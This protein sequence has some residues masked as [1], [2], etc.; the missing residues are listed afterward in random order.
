[1]A[2]DTYRYTLSRE[3]NPDGPS[4]LFIML[5]PSTATATT[6]DRTMKRLQEIGILWRFGKIYVGNLYPYCSSR[7]AILTEVSIPP[8]V[9]EENIRSIREMAAL[10][11]TVV[12]AWGTKGPTQAEPAWLKEIVTGH[13][14]CI[15]KS[16]KG[17]PKHPLQWG[18]WRKGFPAKPVL[19]R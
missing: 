18:D 19:F 6:D 15:S 1:M 7:P 11:D 17:V 2:T 3:L 14:Y 5:N 9:M 8:E 16:V 13:A 4:V 10:A 12:Y